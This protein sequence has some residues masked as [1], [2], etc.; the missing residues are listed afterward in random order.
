M[1]SP[2]G[3]HLYN[4]N[5]MVSVMGK[6]KKMP[7]TLGINLATGI[8]MI[9]PEKK[10]DGPQ[11]DWT[12]EKLTHYSIEGKHVFLEL[13]KPSR[14]IDF[15]AGAK[16]TAEEIV[17]SLGE[18]AGM[19]RAE[20]LREVLA[21]GS[22]GKSQRKGHMLY[23]FMAQGEDEVTVAENDDVIIL[24]DAQSEEWWKVRRVKNGKE[25]VVPSSYVEIT[26]VVSPPPATRS[27]SGINA[28]RSTVEQNRLEEERLAREAMKASQPREEKASRGSEV[29]P[30]LKLPSRG[31][32]L[33][34]RSDDNVRSSQ[35]SRRDSRDKSSSAKSSIYSPPA[36]YNPFE[37]E[38]LY[39]PYDGTE[40]DSAKVRTWTDRTGSFKVEAQFIGLNE[41]KIHLHKLNGVKIAVPVSKMAAVDLEYVE[42]E[43]GVSLDEDKPLSAIRAKSRRETNGVRKQEPKAGASV[44]PRKPEYDW[45]D[46]FL[47]CGVSPYQC[48]RYGHAFNKDSMDESVLPDINASVLRTLGL[49]EG[50]ILRVMKFLDNKYGR[51]GAKSKLRNVSFGGE[52][53][54]GNEDGEDGNTSPPGSGGLFSGPG[55][56]L[57][58]NTRKGR[59]APAVQTNDIVDSKVF[60]QRN[61]K[62]ES[63]TSIDSPQPPEPP[64]KD[65]KGGFDDDAWDVKPSKQSASTSQAPSQTSTAPSAPAA[66]AT[67]SAPVK[68]TPTGAMA[69]L[70]LLSKPLEPVV[71]HSTGAQPPQPQQSMPLPQ[72]IQPQQPLQ[73]QPTA[74]QPL[75]QPQNQ[76]QLMQPMQNQQQLM[77]QM[78]N[79]QQPTQ[80]MQ[81]QQQGASPAFFG[82]LAPQMTGLAPQMTGLPQQGSSN[83]FQQPN[84]QQTG[85]SQFNPPRQRPQA[86]QITQQGPIMPPPPPRPLSA[87]Q[88]AS[89]QSGFGPPPLQPQLTGVVAQQNFPNQ[90]GSNP[91]SLNELNRLRLQQQQ[92]GKQQPQMQPQMTGFGQQPPYSA[93]F[94]SP[95]TNQQTGMGQF[96]QMQPQMTGAQQQQSPFILGQQAGSPFADPQVQM[97]RTGLQPNMTGMPQHAGSINS[98]LPPPLQPQATGMQPQPTGLQSQPTGLQSQSTGFSGLNGLNNRPGFGQ[99]PPPM[100][101]LP[102][103]YSQSV[104]PPPMPQQQQQAPA[105]LQPQKTGPA[106]PVRFGVGNDAKKLMPQPTGRRANLSQASELQNVPV[107][108]SQS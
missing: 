56:T 107:F 32:S 38:S 17:S 8:I 76:Q 21:A 77:Q 62:T 29:G 58:N 55:G 16:D 108:S 15:H 106:P 26:G 33:M 39:L 43:S 66:T 60:Q 40:P 95:F 48:E 49:K 51:T 81:N 23:E 27:S 18:L 46:F 63:N 45:F 52:E 20:G 4:I 28:G 91:Q 103:Q 36:P 70:T 12:A 90:S 99:P 97:Q 82:Q 37:D 35:K 98:V 100:P 88:N 73:S 6:Q 44:E 30:G 101:S 86:P 42:Q 31:S 5:E 9:I 87:P 92:M 14:S 105:P 41:G 19:S 22:Q 25:G 96:S 50:D 59:P 1:P 2:G 67:A 93:G 75:Q 7:T 89:G 71:T 24:D 64:S 74:Q 34:A 54:I 85:Q 79:Q 104:S 69:D 3:F 84:F 78:Q 61:E 65:V 10:K 13:V 80:Q 72:T 102:P 83:Q 68:A 57:K 53:V 94:Q 11:Q 47:Q